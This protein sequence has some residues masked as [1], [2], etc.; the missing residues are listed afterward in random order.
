MNTSG[1]DMLRPLEVEFWTRSAI[2]TQIIDYLD[3]IETTSPDGVSH[4][5]D[6]CPVLSGVGAL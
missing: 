1:A 2:F 5:D 6:R 4:L 3:S